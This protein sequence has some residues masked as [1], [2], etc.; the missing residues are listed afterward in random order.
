MNIYKIYSCTLQGLFKDTYRPYR[1]A[2]VNK[3]S[4]DEWMEKAR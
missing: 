1:K 3:E 4:P 2:F